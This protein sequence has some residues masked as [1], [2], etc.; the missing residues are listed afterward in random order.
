MQSDRDKPASMSATRADR[1]FDAD[2]DRLL[3]GLTRFLLLHSA[4]G[5]FELRDTVQ[6]VGRAYG[7]KAEILAVAEGAV[8]TVRHPDGQS[9]Q[10]TVRIGPDLTRLDLVSKAKFLVNRILA[11]ELSAAAAC[12]I[13]SSWESS[14]EPYPPWLRVIGVVLFAFGFAPGVQQ[15]W[16]EVMAAVI[17]AA[18]MGLMFIGADWIRGLRVLVPIVGTL[19]VAVVA[20]EALHAQ[21][22][23]GGPV[24]LMIPGLFI[25]IPGDLLCA[26]TAEIA[27]GQFTP[28]AVR[29]AQAAVTLLQLAAGVII[30]AELTGVGLRALS[31]PP[32]PGH[33]LPGWLIVV[34]WIP[35]TI[36]L[37]L[38][39]NARMRDVPWMLALVYLAWG[40]QELVLAHSLVVPQ[41][42]ETGATAAVFVA[43]TLLA[44]AAGV[45]EQFR[46]L[47]PRSVTI[48]GGFF[49]LTVGAVALQGLTALAGNPQVQGFNDIRDATSETVALTLG[50]I[51]GAA[52]AAAIAAYRRRA[53]SAS[54]RSGL[55]AH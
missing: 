24:L 43:A 10:D 42:G 48:L 5:A 44:F 30:A 15:T 20:F 13:L 27:V 49:A 8:L 29:L 32:A 26:A 38:T 35:F 14:R 37:A 1:S 12:R 17:L 9:Y 19:V 53:S 23:P 54:V 47:P 46:S 55:A 3:S 4:E 18:V 50:L 2:V 33:S 22:A 52:P 31:Q 21:D 39:F 25:L 40:V 36:G 7:A 45:L 41:E 6:A 28:G 34:A 51:T 16:R 11:G